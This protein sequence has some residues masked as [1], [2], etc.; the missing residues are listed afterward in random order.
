MR[1]F[2]G[3]ESIVASESYSDATVDDVLE[4]FKDKE[5]IAIDLE[6]QGMDPHSKKI[7]SMQLGD[8]DNQYFIDC[9]TI[10]ILKFKKLLESRECVI[11]NS[12]FEYKFLKANGIVI[13]SIY[14]T[15]LA[16]C[17]I[18]CGYESFGYSLKDVC[19]RYL[20][21]E[22]NKDTRGQFHLIKDQPFTDSQIVYGCADVQ[23]L[24]KIKDIQKVSLEKYNLVYCA[25]LEFQAVKAIGDIE[26]NGMRLNADKWRE[27][28]KSYQVEVQKVQDQ[29]DAIIREEPKLAK[30][31]PKYIQGNIF[32]EPERDLRINYGSPLQI[33]ALID[34]LGFQ[35]ESTNDRELSKLIT[36][37]KLFGALQKFRELNKV[38]GTYGESFL[39]YINPETGR[40]HSDFWQVL[41]TGRLSSS[42]P[43]LQNI[44]ADNKFRNCFE[45]EEGFLWV[46]IDY[47]SQELRLMADQSDEQGFIDVLNRGEDLHCYVG[48]MLTGRKITKADKAERTQAK[49]INFMKPYGGGPPKLAD[50]ASISLEEAESIFKKYAEAFPNLDKYLKSQAAFAKKNCYSV[51]PEP[52]LRR[53]WFPDMRIAKQLREQKSEDWKRIL[54]IEGQTERNGMNSPIQGGGADVCKEALVQ[55]RELVNKYNH[56]RS[57][58]VANLVCTVH[59]AIDCEVREDLAEQ[60]SKEMAEI[61]ILCAN[62]YMKKVKMEVDI[63][64][65][66]SW[67]K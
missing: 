49:N 18:Y 2:V 34:T 26:Y 1:Y 5:S 51:T 63:T 53:R 19:K 37:H 3:N 35:V 9:R 22:L 41:N 25:N 62:K 29:L 57:E 38:V 8:S 16:E 66:K 46:S 6:T 12:K 61:M 32:G 64:I 45:A 11:H 67:S 10:N 55:V 24:H 60:F 42:N 43:N 13:E 23:Y 65:T 56:G 48:T 4:Y 31:V 7:L 44:P 27:N 52:G 28:A 15:M 54:T 20:D 17:V 30:F 59:D 40:I 21:I 14:D 50:M 36:H 47:S 39:E 58:K 33:K